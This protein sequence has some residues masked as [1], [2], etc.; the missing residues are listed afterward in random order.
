MVRQAPFRIRA[1]TRARR[2]EKADR[3]RRRGEAL[4]GR[5]LRA[6]SRE[7]HEADLSISEWDYRA[8]LR[9]LSVSLR[10]DALPEDLRDR[11]RTALHRRVCGELRLNTWL[12]AMRAIRE[13]HEAQGPSRAELEARW[14]KASRGWGSV[15][16]QGW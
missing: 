9:T 14:R 4:A 11:F 10:V 13:W 5:R 2:A 7:R 8:A 1:A 3:S 12:T 16:P 15:G 6:G